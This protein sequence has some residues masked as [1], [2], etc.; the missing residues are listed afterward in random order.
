[1][2]EALGVLGRV[3]AR[4][5]AEKS[6]VPLWLLVDNESVVLLAKDLATVSD[7]DISC[8]QKARVYWLRIQHI[9]QHTPGHLRVT[10][11]KGHILDDF[12]EYLEQGIFTR[13]E[14]EYN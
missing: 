5:T 3:L 13:F 9:F 6:P 10:W 2:L 4:I 12:P 1:M 14:A 11:I 8:Q 7:Y